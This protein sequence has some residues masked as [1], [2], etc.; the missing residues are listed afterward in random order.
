MN[1]IA[2]CQ[3]E[4]TPFPMKSEISARLKP[5]MSAPMMGSTA[6]QNAGSALLLKIRSI[7]TIIIKNPTSASILCPPFLS[8]FCHFLDQVVQ[9]FYPVVAVLHHDGVAPV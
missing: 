8:L 3:V 2:V 5:Q 4:P 7:I 9:F 6:K 1:R